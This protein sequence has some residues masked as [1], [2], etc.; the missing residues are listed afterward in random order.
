M[1]ETKQ[2]IDEYA[3]EAAQ[4]RAALQ[5]MQTALIMALAE[6]GKPNKDGSL[7]LQ[8]PVRARK[9]AKRIESARLAWSND[10]FINKG[11]LRVKAT[12]VKDNANNAD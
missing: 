4:L 11:S 10:D 7:T 8:V 12:M 5:E 3:N 2:L 6:Y 9:T 1:S